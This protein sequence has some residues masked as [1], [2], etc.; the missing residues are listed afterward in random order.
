MNIPDIST[1]LSPDM[2]AHLVLVMVA[3]I[4]SF[5][6][7]EVVKPFVRKMFKDQAQNRSIVRLCA[8]GV[9]AWVGYTMGDHS[10]DI[11]FGAGAGVLNAWLVAIVKAKL[12]QRFHVKLKALNQQ[13][14]LS[15]FDDQEDLREAIKAELDRE[16]RNHK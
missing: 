5:G 6:A 4:L 1:F 2:Q 11:L 3:S 10:N 14:T 8:I 12:E 13:N 9:G 15:P 16:S 7:T